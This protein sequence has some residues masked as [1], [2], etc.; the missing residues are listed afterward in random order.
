MALFSTEES[1]AAIERLIPAGIKATH[2]LRV[3]SAI[4]SD[5]GHVAELIAFMATLPTDHRAATARATYETSSLLCAAP[6]DYPGDEAM[7]ALLDEFRWAM[8]EV[9]LA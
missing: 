9:A 5:A 7:R 2:C 8:A 1:V 3:H 4:G 6:S